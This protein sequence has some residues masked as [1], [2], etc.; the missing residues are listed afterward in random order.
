MIYMKKENQFPNVFLS[1]PC[2]YHRA[3]ACTPIIITIIR[4][5]K[6]KNKEI[7]ANYVICKKMGGTEGHD[8]K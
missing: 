6:I 7:R 5:I 8:V 2:A 1:P 4:G 3:C